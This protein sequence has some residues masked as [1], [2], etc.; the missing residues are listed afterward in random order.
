MKSETKKT[1]AE[2]INKVLNYIQ[3]HLTEDINIE[4]LSNIAHFS[5]YHF[6]R[7]FRGMVGE[8]VG[9]YTKRLRLER[10]AIDISQ[11]SR[12]ITDIA[13]EANY[14]T[15]ESFCRAFTNQF[16]LTPKAYR[17]ERIKTIDSKLK[18]F[19]TNI[20]KGDISMLDVKI[21]KMEVKKVIYVRHI[22]PYTKCEK[23]WK[24]LCE[25][26]CPKNLFTPKTQMIGLC[27]DDPDITPEEKIRYDACITIDKDIEVAGEIKLQEIPA[28]NYAS[29]IHTGPYT[30]LKDT[31]IHLYG[32]WLPQSGKEIRHAPSMEIY[33]N[34]PH[35]TKPS[36][37]ET[38]ILLP[39]R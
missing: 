30:E 21:I 16:K 27:Y 17:K 10:A 9:Q 24:T 3:N 25:W 34:D 37:L 19:N 1:Y 18:I 39:I 14:E 15:L 32:K 11:T 13:F 23:A 26:A 4:I 8:T 31:Y 2:R 22:G 28:G 20:S 12:R 5:P 33:L 36:D 6:H 7:I 29:V 35:T 38:Q